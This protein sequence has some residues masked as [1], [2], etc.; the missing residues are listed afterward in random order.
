MCDDY[1]SDLSASA[2]CQEM[3]YST[4]SSWSYGNVWTSVQEAYDIV[5]DNVNC[6]TGSFEECSYDTTHNCGH[7]EDVFLTCGRCKYS[8]QLVISIISAPLVFTILS[9]KGA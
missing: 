4:A 6:Q 2:I 7:T 5:M 1:F 3:G 8:N 9:E